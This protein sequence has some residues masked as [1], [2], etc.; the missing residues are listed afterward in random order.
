MCFKL[1]YFSSNDCRRKVAW[2]IHSISFQVARAMVSFNFPTIQVQTKLPFEG[3]SYPRAC[4]W[5]LGSL[6]PHLTYQQILPALYSIHSEPDHFS[7]QV[8]LLFYYKALSFLNSLAS[9]CPLTVDS[10]PLDQRL[11]IKLYVRESTYQLKWPFMSFS[12]CAHS[13]PS[14]TVSPILSSSLDLFAPHWTPGSSSNT[15]YSPASEPLCLL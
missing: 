6:T 15:R 10:S 4:P 7:A 14:L 2:T 9:A 1:P 5:L 11:L 8:H 13:V 3:C 12:H